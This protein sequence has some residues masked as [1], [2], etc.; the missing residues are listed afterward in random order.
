MQGF[1]QGLGERKNNRYVQ[2]AVLP[3]LRKTVTK[4]EEKNRGGKRMTRAKRKK[5]KRAKE[6]RGKWMKRKRR[7]GEK[8]NTLDV[9]DKCFLTCGAVYAHKIFVFQLWRRVRA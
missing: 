6:K 9:M 7:E 3:G 5:G 1:D 4:G 8:E 2:C